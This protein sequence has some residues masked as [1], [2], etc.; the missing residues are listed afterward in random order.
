MFEITQQATYT[1]HYKHVV[2]STHL[3]HLIEAIRAGH[4]PAMGTSLLKY[5]HTFSLQKVPDVMYGIEVP[6]ELRKLWREQGIDLESANEVFEYLMR[7]GHEA[8]E[9]Q[10]WMG[11]EDDSGCRI[12]LK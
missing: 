10:D 11:V 6:F 7:Q 2:R 8:Q 5:L 1:P 12:R 9:L 4:S 3:E